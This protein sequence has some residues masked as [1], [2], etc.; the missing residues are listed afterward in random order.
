[1]IYPTTSRPVAATIRHVTY[2]TDLLRVDP[3]L[4]QLAGDHLL[5]RGL[6]T[7]ARGR[8][9]RVSGGNQ[10]IFMGKIMGF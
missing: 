8:V 4:Q 10:G 6:G 7:A 2:D 1:M 9:S 5:H 3:R